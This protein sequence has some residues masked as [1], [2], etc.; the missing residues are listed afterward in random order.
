M[1]AP[2][3]PLPDP[4]AA[5][6]WWD[7]DGP[8]L[9]IAGGEEKRRLRLVDAKGKALRVPPGRFAFTVEPG[10]PPGDDPESLRLAGERVVR[11]AER[12]ERLA[13]EVDVPLLWEVVV[14]TMSAEPHP[15]DT[16]ADL[17]LA[18]G[19]GIS[20]AALVVA[21]AEDDLHFVR[22]G[23]GW[24]PRA[25]EAVAQLR[26]ERARTAEREEDTSRF[27]RALGE[28]PWVPSGSDV[29]R[30]GLAALEQV[31]LHGDDADPT[32]IK[33]ADSLL[34]EVGLP[35]DLPREGA[36][37][38]LRH[39]GVFA[40]DDVNL[41]I[42]AH[43]LATTFAE[44]V[45]E[46]AR[47]EV[48]TAGRRDLTHL[49]TLSIDSASTREIDDLL[50]IEP[51]VGETLRLGVHIADASAFVEPGGLL[52]RTARARGVTHYFPE[53]RLP[54]LPPAISEDAASL[55][56][57]VDR[58]ALS[59]FADVDGAGA[60]RSFEIV[61]SVVRSRRRSS[62]DEVDRAVAS[63]DALSLLDRVARC[64]TAWRLARGAVLLRSDEID[65]H[66]QDGVVIAERLPADSRSRDIVTEAMVVAGEVAAR[67]ALE[68]GVPMPYRSQAAPTGLPPTPPGGF[69][70]PREVRDVRRKLSRARSSI[71]PAPH[72]SLG[73]DAY[74][75]ATSPLRRY[76]DLVA[77][78]QI[79]DA[80]YDRD[81]LA[82]IVADG[83]R[84]ERVAR[85]AEREAR[86]YWAL[87][88]LADR[89]GETIEADVVETEP[90]PVV[91]LRDVPREQPLPSL[92]G[93]AEAGDRVRLEIVRVRPRGGVAVLR[94]HDRS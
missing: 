24:E 56:E 6:L 72:G 3:K 61:R 84:H 80:P 57:G 4:G 36:F 15:P 38:A 81:T 41:P 46:A 87:R 76:P 90:R 91:S 34:K 33:L 48:G 10:L 68:R 55:L 75:Q 47:V 44:D 92:S 79:L 66:V 28:T 18:G 60:V 23:E 27:L 21:L 83:E 26:V 7:R 5:V 88:W 86:E 67:F 42:L 25:R 2:P 11:L 43:G 9:A 35:T 85:R 73:L 16:L 58:P 89:V 39:A 93:R 71:E 30:R 22:R 62:Y 69:S 82:E 70:S 1:G 45:N 40:A 64:R 31:A 53:R 77:H 52:D 17:A 32:S 29:E 50:S 37:L 19:D 12:V 49:E 59:F 13:E 51:G 94:Y 14:E 8:R 54:M 20:R 78:R 63:D 74:V 65:L